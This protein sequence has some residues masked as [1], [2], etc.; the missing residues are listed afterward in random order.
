MCTIFILCVNDLCGYIIT[1]SLVIILL[2]FGTN[3]TDM[4]AI[5]TF[6]ITK[7]TSRTRFRR[8]QMYNTTGI[9]QY[10]KYNTHQ[11]GL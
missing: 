3:I 6:E 5:C 1:K 4:R 8:Y 2:Y 9:A 11:P 10:I 7:Y